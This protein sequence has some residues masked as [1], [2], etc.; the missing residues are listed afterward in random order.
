MRAVCTTDMSDAEITDLITGICALQDM[1]LDG[2]GPNPA[3]R[4]EICRLWTAIRVFLK[5]PSASSLG[6]YREDRSAALIKLNKELKDMIRIAHGGIAAK[7]SYE[8]TP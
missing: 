2:G 1:I 7:Y 5:D 6:E 8:P 3:I 4:K